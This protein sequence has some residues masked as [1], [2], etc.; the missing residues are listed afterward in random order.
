MKR[1]I[2]CSD[3][4]FGSPQKANVTNVVKLRDAIAAR[5]TDNAP[6]RVFYDRGV[7]T[8]GTVLHRLIGGA[9]GAGLSKNIQ[10]CYRFLMYNY[11][12]HGDDR[13]QIF[14][15]GFS[16]GAYTVRSLAGFLRNSG[17]LKLEHADKFDEAFKLY[18][19]KQHG[20]DSDKAKN[21]RKENSHPGDIQVEFIGVWDTV[22]ALGVPAWGI[23]NLLNKRHEFHDVELSGCVTRGYHALAIDER[24][25]SFQP[26][27]WKRFDKDGKQIFEPKEGQTIKQ[28]WFAGYHSDVG[29][30]TPYAGLSDLAF[31]W[32]IESTKGTEL[33]FDQDYLAK[34]IHPHALAPAHDSRAGIWG[35]SPF[36]FERELGTTWPQME[37]VHPAVI[38]R[39]RDLSPPYRA[40]NLERYIGKHP[41]GSGGS[42]P[43]PAELRSERA[44]VSNPSG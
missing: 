33:G 23:G 27:I 17:L 12:Q 16:R 32:M 40:P 7:G 22:G 29:G 13:D 3:G 35:R 25:R 37:S 30:G 18:R 14:L 6:Q 26:S 4:T 8:E 5:G 1:L 43:I 11:E 10:D 20:P 44:D 38:E 15:F 39:R 28:V 34:Y 2:V 41:D 21:F 9:T 36:I 19:S 42:S 24:R 31:E